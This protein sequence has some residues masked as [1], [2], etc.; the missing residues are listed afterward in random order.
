MPNPA[1]VQRAEVMIGVGSL[2]SVGP[3]IGTAR[4]RLG[5]CGKMHA[6]GKWGQ[7][8]A[9]LNQKLRQSIRCQGFEGGLELYHRSERQERS[10]SYVWKAP[11]V[12][13]RPDTLR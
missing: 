2:L 8:S 11:V 12:G 10:T 1:V 6:L 4:P 7:C 9:L 3:E 13:D 5:Y